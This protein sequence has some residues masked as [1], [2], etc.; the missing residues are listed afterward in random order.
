MQLLMKHI[1]LSKNCAE[2]HLRQDLVADQVSQKRACVCA[3]ERLLSD[4]CALQRSCDVISQRANQARREHADQVDAIGRWVFPWMPL[5]G[6]F[7]P[8]DVIARWSDGRHWSVSFSLCDV[9]RSRLIRWLPLVGEFFPVWRHQLV[10]QSGVAG[11]RWS[12]GCLRE[13]SFSI[14]SWEAYAALKPSLP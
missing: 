5:V 4:A 13:V 14:G 9:I 2:L 10:S 1:F 11:A 8:C 6:E 7:S 3:C 12:G